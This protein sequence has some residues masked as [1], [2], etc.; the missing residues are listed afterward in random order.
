MYDIACQYHKKFGT[1]RLELPEP[2]QLD[3]DNMRIRWFIDKFHMEAHGPD[4]QA[5]FSLYTSKGAGRSNGGVMEQEW[6]HIKKVAF[7]TCEMGDGSRRSVL[8]DHWGWWNHIQQLR[9]GTWLSRTLC[10]FCIDD[11]IRC[12]AA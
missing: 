1:R 4:C 11:S 10:V 8:N 3:L 7:S 12:L 9:L 6:S 2:L 5:N